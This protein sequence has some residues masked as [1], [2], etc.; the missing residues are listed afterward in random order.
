MKMLLQLVQVVVV[1]EKERE[2]EVGD[3]DKSVKG[4]EG[5]LSWIYSVVVCCR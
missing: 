4:A 5:L 2:V 1:A 3:K